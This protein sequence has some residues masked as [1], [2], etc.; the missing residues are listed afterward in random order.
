METSDP[1]RFS[2]YLSPALAAEIRRLAAQE[3]RTVTAQIELLLEQALRT[4]QAA[5]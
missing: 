2:L 5:A 3:R 4:M 1:A